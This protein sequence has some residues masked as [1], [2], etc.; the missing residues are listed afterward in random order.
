MRFG[1]AGPP[2]GPK[3]LSRTGGDAASSR[4][5]CASP[6]WCR[7]WC[8]PMPPASCSPPIRSP[9]LAIKPSST[10]AAGWARR[11]SQVQSRQTT[12]CSMPTAGSWSFRSGGVSWR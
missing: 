12:I 7:R 11:L 2:S 3:E 6:L 1:S 9:A 10:R 4:V 5:K 8:Q